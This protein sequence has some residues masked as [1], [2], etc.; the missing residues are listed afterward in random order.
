[1]ESTSDDGSLLG[2]LPVVLYWRTQTLYVVNINSLQAGIPIVSMYESSRPV[3]AS[4]AAAAFFFIG[5]CIRDE[6]SLYV[7]L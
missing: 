7:L 1:M 2:V 6:H 4:A 3:A 5:L